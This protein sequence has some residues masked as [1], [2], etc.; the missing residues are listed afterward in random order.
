MEES[1]VRLLKELG[2]KRRAKPVVSL[3]DMLAK[4]QQKGQKSAPASPPVN[5][6]SAA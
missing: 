5:E 1:E 6:P 3:G 2:L 4:A